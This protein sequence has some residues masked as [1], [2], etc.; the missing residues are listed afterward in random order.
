MGVFDDSD[1]EHPVGTAQTPLT[2]EMFVVD[3]CE[4]VAELAANFGSR[5]MSIEIQR[6]KPIDI[7]LGKQRRVGC[8]DFFSFCPSL[9]RN[10]FTG[11]G[12]TPDIIVDY[13]I[14]RFLFL[15]C[16]MMA[17]ID[18]RAFKAALSLIKRLQMAHF[19]R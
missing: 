19:R 5:G 14:Y 7:L 13:Q 2:P 16:T 8:T 3:T 6:D 9:K 10:E 4:Q 1:C 15:A 11:H 12:D 17:Q 18:K